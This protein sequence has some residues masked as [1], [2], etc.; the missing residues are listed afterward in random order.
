MKFLADESCDFAIV[1]A[2][3]KAGYDVLAISEISPGA[4]DVEVL[5]LAAQE[6]RILITE[7]KDFGQLVFA[8]CRISSGV[9]FL[10]YPSTV[11][12]QFSREIVKSVKRHGDK[13]SDT[14]TVIQPGKIRIIK[15]QL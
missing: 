4:E 5:N 11:R 7:D 10:R 12:L 14:F 13:L 1:R 6:K 2:L 3:R 9:I 15:T 8:H